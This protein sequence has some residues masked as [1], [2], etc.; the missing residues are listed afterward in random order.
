MKRVLVCGDDTS[1]IEVV[2][3]VLADLKLAEVY[4]LPDCDNIIK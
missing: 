2:A 4:S 3:A 1:I